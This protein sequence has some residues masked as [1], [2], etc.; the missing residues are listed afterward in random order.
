MTVYV[1]M[2]LPRPQLEGSDGVHVGGPRYERLFPMFKDILD[3]VEETGLPVLYFDNQELKLVGFR[4]EETSKKEIRYWEWAMHID[5]L[6][7][8]LKTRRWECLIP[9]FQTAEGRAEL[10]RVLSNSRMPGYPARPYKPHFTVCF[11]ENEVWHAFKPGTVKDGT[12]ESWCGMKTK[13]PNS[14]EKRTDIT[15]LECKKRRKNGT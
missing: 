5:D 7:Y 11:Q 12:C 14:T 2:P 13:V 1:T 8:D 9:L 6:V 4:M 3:A 15:C 10:A